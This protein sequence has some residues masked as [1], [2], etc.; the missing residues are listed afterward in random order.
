M[1]GRTTNW[2]MTAIGKQSKFR[3]GAVAAKIAIPKGI[4]P[5]NIAVNEED[6]SAEVNMY[7]EVVTNAPTDFWTG[8]RIEGLYIIL[9]DFLN[10]ME[11]L[12]DKNKITFHINSPGGEVFAGVAIY[13]RMREFKGTVYTVVD[14]LAASAASIIAQGA[15][16]GSRRVCRGSLTM[17]HGASSFMFGYYNSHEMESAINQV[18]AVDKSISEI[19]CKVTGL[20][21]QKIKSM[22]D[23]TTWMSAQEAVDNGFA[24]EIL[25]NTEKVTMSLNVDKSIITVNG[26]PMSARGLANVPDYI[27]V[28]NA[29]T[30]GKPDVINQNNDMGGTRMTYEELM[31]SEPELVDKIKQEAVNSVQVAA[32]QKM[33]DEAVEKEVK[34]LQ[35][36]D[37]VADKIA[38][39]ELINRAKYG[40]VK[41]SAGDLAL[42]AL[43]AQKDAGANFLNEVKKDADQSGVNDVMPQPNSNLPQEEQDKND[44]AAGAALIAG[45]V[46]G[47]N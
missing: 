29:V 42:E 16:K 18:D 5:Y 43:K 9:S 41:M 25:D 7:G 15:S 39:K 44:V 32:N 26:I 1:K 38:D 27:P 17:I 35:S 34:R 6:N 3:N 24:D 28:E 47:G 2:R 14:G 40:A 13:N 30:T 11:R 10:D 22:M 12:K 37:E 21:Q 46:Q 36:I 45:I 23:K 19:Y 31:K 4:Q 8:E 20:E 33:I